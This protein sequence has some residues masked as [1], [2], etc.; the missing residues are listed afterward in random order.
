MHFCNRRGLHPDP[1]L[2]LG[3]TPIP[4][5]RE[6]KFLGLIFDSKLTFKPHLKYL[7]TK[8]QK[9]LNLLRFVA[10]NDWGADRK[11]LHRLY[12]AHVRSKIDYGCTVYGSA[13]K[14]A[15]RT[16]DP[17]HHQGLRLCLG[18]FRTSNAQ[19]LYTEANEPSL[20][21]RRQKLSLQ[22]AIK[23]H[24]NQANPA[25]TTVF[26][27]QFE[28]MFAAKPSIIPPLEFVYIR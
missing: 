11:V 22:Y 2:Q 19:S 8:C 4:V 14:S 13:C 24:S 9:A 27:R 23:L 25:Y 17:I 3:T 18:A 7:K 21:D 16:L 12:I 15:L 1:E 6:Y 26:H 10:N 20:H 28:P 5:V